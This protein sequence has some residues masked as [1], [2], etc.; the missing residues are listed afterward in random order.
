MNYSVIGYER[1]YINMKKVII[2]I[3]ALAVSAAMVFS[4]AGCTENT[5]TEENTTDV[6]VEVESG[7]EA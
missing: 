4:F 7:S 1:R 6:V 3:A 2:T 5:P